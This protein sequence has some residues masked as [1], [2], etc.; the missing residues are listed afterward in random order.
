MTP[1]REAEIRKIVDKAVEIFSRTADEREKDFNNS[2]NPFAHFEEEREYILSNYIWE[3]EESKSALSLKH[4]T[5]SLKDFLKP[6]V[7][8]LISR[9]LKDV[10]E[11]YAEAKA[12]PER[13]ET[14]DCIG[15]DS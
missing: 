5:M 2:P 4:L 14:H 1:Q 7:D 13:A 11:A 8:D 15:Y 12:P 6:V 3:I 10:A 9:Y